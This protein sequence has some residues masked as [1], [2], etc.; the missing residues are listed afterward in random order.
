MVEHIHKV[1]PARDRVHSCPT[2]SPRARVLPIRA[3]TR[4]GSAP[5]RF[6]MSPG[7]PYRE[8]VLPPDK[9]ATAW[10]IGHDMIPRPRPSRRL[11]QARVGLPD[12]EL[13][14]AMS[15]ICRSSMAMFRL[16]KEN[17]LLHGAHLQS[18]AVRSGHFGYSRRRCLLSNQSPPKSPSR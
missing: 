11:V 10:R 17:P 5:R 12:P 14:S 1:P 13:L 18:R 15:S 2:P 8:F 16:N 4:S 9:I 3:E 7:R 6:I